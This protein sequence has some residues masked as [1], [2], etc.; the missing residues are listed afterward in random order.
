MDL[1]NELSSELALA[2]LVE[3]KH[4]ERLNKNDVLALIGRVKE[5][6]L[7]L[8]ADKTVDTVVLPSVISAKTISH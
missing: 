8:S 2:F 4:A 5:V 1:V 6:L 7:P 3:K